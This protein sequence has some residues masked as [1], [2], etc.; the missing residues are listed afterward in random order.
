MRNNLSYL[1]FDKVRTLHYKEGGPSVCSIVLECQAKTGMTTIE[2]LSGGSLPYSWCFF[3][4]LYG[5]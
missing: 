2:L 1:E 5:R 3:R 4:Q